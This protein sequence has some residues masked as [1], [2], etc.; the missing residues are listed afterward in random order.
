MSASVEQVVFFF[1]FE[2]AF[3]DY[4]EIG[5]MLEFNNCLHCHY[6]HKMLLLCSTMPK[7][8]KRAI[9]LKIMPA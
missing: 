7:S 8:D 3:Q 6:A 1:N 9:M 4:V 2:E 5:V